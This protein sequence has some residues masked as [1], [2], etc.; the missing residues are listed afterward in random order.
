MAQGLQCEVGDDLV[1]VH[2][3]GCSG[4]ALDNVHREGVVNV[5]GGHGV[6]GCSDGVANVCRDEAQ[7]GVGQRRRLLNQREGADEVPV[8]SELD[9][10]DGEVEDGPFG[11][12][13]PQCGFRDSHGAQA[14]LFDSY[15]CVHVV[16]AMTLGWV[17]SS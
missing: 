4:A 8:G 1:G 14:V 5:A 7:L 10:A 16:I 3:G 12:D 6:A 13:S 2:V 17:I 11:V 15:S 9:A